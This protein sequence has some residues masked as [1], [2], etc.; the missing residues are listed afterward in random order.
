[1]AT[2]V[3]INVNTHMTLDKQVASFPGL[4]SHTAWEWG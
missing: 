1:M 3:Q 2:A 4:F